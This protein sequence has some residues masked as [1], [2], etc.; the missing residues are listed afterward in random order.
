FSQWKP[1]A[2]LVMTHFLT[3]PSDFFWPPKQPVEV[4]EKTTTEKK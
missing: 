2:H 4:Q 1:L 3:R